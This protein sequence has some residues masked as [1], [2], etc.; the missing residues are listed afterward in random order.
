LI[1]D[2]V[3]LDFIARALASREDARR[4]GIYFTASEVR[5]RLDE[6]LAAAKKRI[7]G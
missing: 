2:R 3:Q 1:E 7:V 6:M 4:T 5:A